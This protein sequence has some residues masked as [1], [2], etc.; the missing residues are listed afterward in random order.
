MQGQ[1]G[2]IIEGFYLLTL[3]AL[4]W[5][6]GRGCE[7]LLGRGL[8]PNTPQGAG[9]VQSSPTGMFHLAADEMPRG[10]EARFLVTASASLCLANRRHSAS[11]Y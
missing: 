5:V 11:V 9:G 8:V 4:L 10:R 7:P 6:R 2:V 1:T 3:P